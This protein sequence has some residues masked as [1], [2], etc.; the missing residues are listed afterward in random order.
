MAG[1]SFDSVGLACRTTS[2]IEATELLFVVANPFGQ[3]FD[4]RAQMT[5]LGSEAGHRPWVGAN[6]PVF[7]LRLDHDRQADLLGDGGP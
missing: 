4:G 3:C 1:G 2:G 7:Q 6:R 5:D